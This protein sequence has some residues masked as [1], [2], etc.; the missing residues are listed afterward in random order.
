MDPELLDL[1]VQGVSDLQACYN[2][3]LSGLIKAG[4]DL[5]RVGTE[6]DR[7]Q[8][9]FYNAIDG[10]F[11]Q[12]QLQIDNKDKAIRLMLEQKIEWYDVMSSMQNQLVKLQDENTTLKTKN[13]YLTGILNANVSGTGNVLPPGMLQ[14]NFSGKS[15]ADLFCPRLIVHDTRDL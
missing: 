15:S 4:T 8:V 14:E 9:T 7:V 13:E 11:E 3:A 2:H 1:R 12:L 6:F 10:Y 5:N